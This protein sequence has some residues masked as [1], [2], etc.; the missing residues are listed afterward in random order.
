VLENRVTRR[1]LYL[2]RKKI[3]QGWRRFGNE[4]LPSVQLPEYY[5]DK[6]KK[7]QTDEACSTHE[8]VEKCIENIGNLKERGQLKG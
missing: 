2:V 5:F 6:I 7:D 1:I 3:T 4:F 8:R